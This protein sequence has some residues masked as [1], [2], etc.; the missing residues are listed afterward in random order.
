MAIIHTYA[1]RLPLP[2]PLEDRKYPVLVT[3]VKPMIMCNGALIPLL[4]PTLSFLVVF[5]DKLT[6][7]FIFI[8]MFPFVPRLCTLIIGL[9]IKLRHFLVSTLLQS[10][11]NEL[12][13]FL[14]S[15]SKNHLYASCSNLVK[16]SSG[17]SDSSTRLP[18][19][20]NISISRIFRVPLP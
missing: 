18:S 19:L 7:L 4:Y 1:Y 14:P 5:Q 16:E 6:N 13:S 9:H 10:L 12:K 2:I 15:I 11:Y 8:F 17:M 3:F 20:Y